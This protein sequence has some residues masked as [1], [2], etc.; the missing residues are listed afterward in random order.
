MRPPDPPERSPVDRLRGLAAADR[1]QVLRHLSADQRRTAE[2][3]LRQPKAASPPATAPKDL[4][5]D[6]VL[7]EP[8]LS[9]WLAERVAGAAE[10]SRIR[11]TASVRDCLGTA[12]R[13]L[14]PKPARRAASSPSLLARGLDALRRRPRP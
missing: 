2:R 10:P 14:E 13:A 4:S 7:A 6:D 12:L 5:L 11:M 3:L 8:D 1:R 9:P